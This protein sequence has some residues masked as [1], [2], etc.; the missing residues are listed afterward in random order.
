MVLLEHVSSEQV[1]AQT[2]TERRCALMCHRGVELE[3]LDRFMREVIAHIERSITG[4]RVGQK[5]LRV[6]L[7]GLRLSDS[8]QGKVRIKLCGKTDVV[9]VEFTESSE[10]EPQVLLGLK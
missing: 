9:S 2:E 10:G 3:G 7:K 8:A 5:K 1:R 6:D 4:R